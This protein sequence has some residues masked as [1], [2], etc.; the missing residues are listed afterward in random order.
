MKLNKIL[1]IPVAIV[2]ASLVIAIAIYTGLQGGIPVVQNPLGSNNTISEEEILNKVPY[3]YQV[4]DYYYAD[5]DEDGMDE[6]LV[7]LEEE[8]DY[9]T[10]EEYGADI[11]GFR[12]KPIEMMIFDQIN[13]IWITTEPTIVSNS[14]WQGQHIFTPYK[15]SEPYKIIKKEGKDWM[16]IFTAHASFDAYAI[17]P[18]IFIYNETEG[19]QKINTSKELWGESVFT[20]GDYVYLTGCNPFVNEGIEAYELD[21]SGNMTKQREV[22]L[23]DK[24]TCE[25]LGANFAYGGFRDNQEKVETLF[26]SKNIYF[27]IN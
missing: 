18:S 4:Y 5:L 22:Y 19:I 15:Y 13:S 8:D 16:V 11:D 17:S 6:V 21:L 25:F 20:S 12:E 24:I 14:N 26:N 23:E 2:I 27:P 7:I 3:A 9:I 1:T 10:E